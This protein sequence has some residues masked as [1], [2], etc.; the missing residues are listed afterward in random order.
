MLK[1]IESWLHARSGSQVVCLGLLLIGVVGSLDYLTGTELSF[2]VFYLVPIG[3]VAWYGKRS[4]GYI[5]CCI[6]AA[7][8]LFI[9]NNS[10]HIYS[11]WLIPIWNAIVRLSFF[12]TAAYLLSEVKAHLSK[13]EAMARTD[14]LT[15]LLNGRAFKDASSLSL[16]LAARHHHQVALGYID[17]DNFKG[18]NDK[19]G[20]DEGDR[21]LKAVAR[22]LTE[23]VRA[24]DV[25]GR[26]GGDEFAIF[27]SEIGADGALTAFHKVHDALTSVAAAQG[28]PIGFSMGVAI[29]PAAPSSIEEALKL[30]DKLMYRVKQS[31]KNKVVF[32]EQLVSNAGALQRV[33]SSPDTIAP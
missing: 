13:E 27:M 1:F 2:S 8:W 16:G 31:G 18:I 15:N 22:T 12:F 24:T 9:D 10:G 30:G 20:H 21:V 33:T 23:S 19:S 29:F 28:W 6:S 5:M 17:V 25:V 32:E 7:T 14:G 4:N 11:Y 3:L 26:L